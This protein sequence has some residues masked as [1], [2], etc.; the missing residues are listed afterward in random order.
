MS[1]PTKFYSPR[2]ISFVCVLCTLRAS[3]IYFFLNFFQKLVRA[4]FFKAKTRLVLQKKHM[5]S[6]KQE[7]CPFMYKQTC[8]TKRLQIIIYIFQNLPN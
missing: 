5:P 8:E 1:L 2:K 4:F 6:F 3:P 7:Y